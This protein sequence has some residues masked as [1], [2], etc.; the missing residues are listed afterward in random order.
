MNKFLMVLAVALLA[1]CGKAPD[2]AHI[3]A[4]GV[5]D[6][7]ATTVLAPAVEPAP[8]VAPEVKTTQVVPKPVKAHVKQQ[9]SAEAAAYATAYANAA[10][11]NAL[12]GEHK[13]LTAP[14]GFKG[15]R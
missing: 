9:N 11:A 14:P 2:S 5:S 4:T 1:A 8:V 7:P 3:L 15:L 12:L 6:V 13:Y 10:K